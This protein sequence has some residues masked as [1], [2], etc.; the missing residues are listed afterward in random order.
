MRAASRLSRM[1]S[2]KAKSGAPRMGPRRSPACPRT[3][4]RSGGVEVAG[5]ARADEQPAERRPAGEEWP[6]RAA[7]P[8]RRRGFGAPRATPPRPGRT[9][10]SGPPSPV[11]RVRRSASHDSCRGRARRRCAG[12]RP[13]PPPA[14]RR[15][16][17]ETRRSTGLGTRRNRLADRT[18]AGNRNS[19]T[20]HG[21]STGVQGCRGA[22]VQGCTGAGCTSAGCTS[23]GCTGAGC[24]GARV[25]RCK[26]PGAE[27]LLRR[28]A[29][30]GQGLL[31]ARAR[32]SDG[33]WLDRKSG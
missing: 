4:R 32:S 8:R 28:A 14:G 16:R 19:G 27:A 11:R 30:R 26:V 7:R 9:R 2:N 13:A 18:S 15:A 12:R 21:D 3:H 23:A 29:V 31:A 24:T 22:Q 10:P 20:R 33:G 25:L 6:N 5:P 1:A 17:R